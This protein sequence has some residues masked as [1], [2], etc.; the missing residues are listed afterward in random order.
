MSKVVAQ[1]N[2]PVKENMPTLNR[3]LEWLKFN[4]RV[5][6]QAQDS[7]TP[8]LERIK[9]LS[10][11][12]SNL[13]EF[14]MK[15]VGG[16]K[17]QHI[18]KYA[19]T[20]E[21]AMSP[22]QQIDEIRNRVQLQL[23]EVDRLLKEEL[24]PNLKKENVS[25]TKWSRLDQEGKD[26]CNNYFENN[27]FPVLTP[28]AVDQGH[29][30]PL[31]STLSTSIA[32]ALR[33][34]DSN[35]KLFARIKVPISFPM[36]IRVPG[37]SS[38]QVRFISMID[39]IRNNLEKLFPKMEIAGFMTFRLIRNIDIEAGEGSD[40]DVED[41]L[42]SISEEVKQRK[43]FAQVVSLEHGPKPDKWLLKF[44]RLELELHE[45]DIYEYPYQLEYKELMSLYSNIDRA[46]LKYQ[47]WQPVSPPALAD[48]TAN[49]FSIIKQKDILVHHPYESF[50]NSVERFIVSAADDPKTL[51]IKMTLYRTSQHSPIVKALM[52]AA[53]LG[54]QVV[55]LI[56]LKARLDEERN[57]YWAKELE[58][59]GVHVVYGVIGL[60]THCKTAMVVRREGTKI[61]TYAHIGTGNYHPQTAKLYT[62]FGLLTAN[63]KIVNDVVELFHFLTGRSLKDDYQKILVAPMNLKKKIID[64]IRKEA[65]NA[66]KGLPA[67]ILVKIN[68]LD[69]KDVI[70]ELYKASAAGVKIQM[71]IRGFCCLIPGKKG[72][73]ENIKVI[74]IIGPFL[75]HSRVYYFRNGSVEREGGQLY[76]GSADWMKRNLVGRVEVATPILEPELKVRILNIFEILLQDQKL[77]WD[78]D[79]NGIYKQRKG[80]NNAIG[81]HDQ[82]M[83]EAKNRQATIGEN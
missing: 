34:Q 43:K 47:P 69:E 38:G 79:S 22:K 64:S 44:L 5:L 52:R 1:K 60:K 16:L 32:V 37:S 18:V 74:S 50:S 57:I 63:K 59:V 70:N 75:E 67:E 66:K 6:F 76:I 73:S 61:K 58:R 65:E 83:I 4:E 81:S 9:F 8:M 41:L 36:W 2:S 80:S 24:K 71:I 51:A 25:L 28:M 19:D 23:V 62:D 7:R 46:D 68:S 20:S 17:R 27:V 30:F 31:I 53:E 35:E 13:D 26:W 56:E 48:D 40:E 11:F 3:E 12:H 78:M 45:E 15:R 54:K 49:I 33:H 10:I 21:G 55:C 42:D 29:P 77:A 72:L 39:L 82:L 14:Y